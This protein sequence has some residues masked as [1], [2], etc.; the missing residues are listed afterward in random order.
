MFDTKKQK[1]TAIL[2]GID[3][4]TID[5]T[6][7]LEE[8]KNLT[9][10]AGA[11]VLAYITQKRERANPA[12]YIGKGKVDE[13]LQMKLE[14]KP[15]MLI[16]ND[17]LSPSQIRNLSNALDLPIID[18]TRLI[19]DIFATNAKT[20]EGKIQV[21]LAQLK[22]NLTR[23]TGLGKSLSRLGGGIGTRGPGETKLESDRRHIRTRISH[24][25]NELKDIAQNRENM[26]RK[27]SKN[28]VFTAALLGYTNAGKSSIMNLLTDAGT[29]AEN[30]LFATLDTTIRAFEISE[31]REAV[32]TDTVGFIEKLPHHLVTSFKTTLEELKYAD[33]LLHVVDASS[34]MRENH[35]SVVNKTLKE[36]KIEGKP[37]I[38]VLNKIDKEVEFPLPSDLNASHS[39]AFSAKTGQG[40]EKLLEILQNI[41]QEGLSELKI[42]V[43]Y[44]NGEVSAF[45]HENCEILESRHI[46]EGSFFKIL[47]DN[48]TRE[49]LKEYAEV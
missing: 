39:V 44:A 47:A 43:P 25:S 28:Q 9:Q 41:M 36:L 46:D 14:L 15:D 13:I 35:I 12:T 24:L 30:K 37:I 29:L 26:R 4:G 22:Y 1:E 31:G 16:F 6:N 33:V 32:L 18:R 20:K 40:Q 8:L 48:G 27:R 34:V 49:R 45:I 11:E 19:L 10:T 21:E 7:S 5:I 23:L 17:E 3:D 38:L 42:L 2:I